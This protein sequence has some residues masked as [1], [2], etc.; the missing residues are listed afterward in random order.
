MVEP[1]FQKQSLQPGLA[2]VLCNR[3]SSRQL[4]VWLPPEPSIPGNGILGCFTSFGM[5]RTLV[6]FIR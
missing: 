2:Y 1:K 3:L 6:G 4:T 5:L